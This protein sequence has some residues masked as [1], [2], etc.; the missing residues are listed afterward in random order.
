MGSSQKSSNKKVVKVDSKGKVTIVGRGKA[1]VTVTAKST[2]LYNAAR[3]KITI[4]VK[5]KK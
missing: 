3:K 1:T 5:A 4:T 2:S